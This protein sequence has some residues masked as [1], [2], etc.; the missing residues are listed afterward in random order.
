MIALLIMFLIS[1]TTSILTA[2]LRRRAQTTHAIR[3]MRESIEQQHQLRDTRTMLL[4]VIQQSS[5][6]RRFCEYCGGP[7][8]AQRCTGCGAPCTE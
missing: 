8:N 2:V 3:V 1:V 6:P 4:H 5:R 7:V